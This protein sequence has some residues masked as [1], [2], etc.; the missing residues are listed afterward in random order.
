MLLGIQASRGVAALVVVMFHAELAITLPQFVGRPLLGGITSFGHAGVDF[1]FVLSGFII[2][3]VHH[4][5]IGRPGAL[6]RYAGR[7]ASRIY[8]PYW[9]VTAVLLSGITSSV[10]ESLPSPGELLRMLLLLPGKEGPVLGVA[11]TLVREM[12]FYV[13]F[14][15]A[16]LDRRLAA[17]A[18]AACLTLGW[19]P[20]PDW[21]ESMRWWGLG[22]F[23][24]LFVFGIGAARVTLHAPVPRPRA[25]AA[26]GIAAFLAAGL[27]ENAG[28]LP[29]T[30]LPGRLAYGLASGLIIVGA[31]AAE[32][33]GHLQVGPAMTTLGAASYS[34]YLVHSPMLGYAQRGLTVTGLATRLPDWVLMAILV[35]VS[36]AA[37]IAF[38]WWVEQPLTMI[39]QRSLRRASSLAPRL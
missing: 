37:G 3:Y 23:D 39:A 2:Y 20:L 27:A 9:A 14:G 18:V 24:L 35:S 10:A 19:A 31:A 34:I 32:R 4:G 38:H 11:W 30:G 36:V 28:L 15:I 33:A 7:R 22:W 5:D 21:A 29:A 17:V 8:P 6:L 1:F 25:L 12:V 13:L 26:L 16:I